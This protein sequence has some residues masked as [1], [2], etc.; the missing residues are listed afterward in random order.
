LLDSLSKSYHEEGKNYNPQK[1]D[2]QNAA[3]K[4]SDNDER[5][6][7]KLKLALTT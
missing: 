3:F 1:I 5:L 6:L 4:L 2:F 7:E